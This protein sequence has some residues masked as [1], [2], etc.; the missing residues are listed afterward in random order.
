MPSIGLARQ[1]RLREGKS[2]VLDEVVPLV[3]RAVVLADEPA[4]PRM[5]LGAIGSFDA[6]GRHERLDGE[7]CLTRAPGKAHLV[8]HYD[9]AF[10]DDISEVIPE[11]VEEGAGAHV[12]IPCQKERLDVRDH[13]VIFDCTVHIGFL[14]TSPHLLDGEEWTEDTVVGDDE[15][16]EFIERPP[17]LCE[18]PP[19]EVPR[20]EIV[21]KGVAGV[22]ARAERAD[23]G[24][25]SRC[26][27]R[28][29]GHENDGRTEPVQRLQVIDDM[30]IDDTFGIEVCEQD[31]R[32]A[33]LRRLARKLT[34]GFAKE[35]KS[36]AVQPVAHCSQGALG[37]GAQHVQPS[38]RANPFF[39]YRST[40]AA[41]LTL[42]L[43]VMGIEPGST[44]TRSAT[45]R[46]CTS[47]IAELTFRLRTSKLFTG[48]WLAAARFLHSMIAT[49]F[50]V[51]SSATAIA[52]QRPGATLWIVASRS[53]GGWLRP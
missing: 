9:G 17:A 33:S 34:V 40:Q 51:P 13:L 2:E 23:G 22:D 38:S 20:A 50:S 16:V 49:S 27:S 24:Y 19:R 36:V 26:E 4:E 52:A 42:P 28:R 29:A 14:E 43:V 53:S 5:G 45:P 21:G 47:D 18:D 3:E 11:I 6:G 48:S 37:L 7:P 10:V 25:R 39:R 32:A 44:T 41:L 31:Q 46:P 1:D 30:G 35:A 15:A 8:S 12:E